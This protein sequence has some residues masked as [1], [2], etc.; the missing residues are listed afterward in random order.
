MTERPAYFDKYKTIKFD[1]SD[2]GVLVMRL[3]S[4]D[5]PVKYNNVHHEEWAPAFTD[6]GMDRDNRVVVLAGSGDSFI[7]GHSSWDR[8]LDTPSD[9]DRPMWGEKMMFRRM[10]EIE[11]PII[12]AVTGPATIHAELGVLGDIILAADHAYFADDGHFPAGEVAGDGVHIVW[13]ELLGTNRGKYFLLTGQRIDAHEALRLGVVNEVMPLADL[14]P[15]AME[16]ANRLAT[17]ADL[18]LKYTRL[19]FVDKW[20]HL[21]HDAVGVGYGMALAQLAHID[22]GW[23]VWNDS[24]E[25]NADFAQFKR[26][27]ARG[28]EPGGA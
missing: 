10:F 28:Q 2:N 16:I 23:M 6:V 13:Q 21:F 25:G 27:Y 15:R 1:R 9:Y 22:R 17:Y 26:L 19:C 14:M 12:C 3:H 4:D 7:D 11:C 20:K 18:T 8:P 5:G 24:K